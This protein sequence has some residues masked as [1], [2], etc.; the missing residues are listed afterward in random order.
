MRLKRFILPTLL[1]V[2]V[3][4]LAIAPMVHA[5]GGNFGLD[6][7]AGRTIPKTTDLAGLIG[8]MLQTV[9]SFVGVLFLLLMVYAGFVYMTAHGDEKKVTSAKQMITGAIIGVVI[10]ASAYAITSFVLGAVAGDGQTTSATT[11]AAPAEN[12]VPVGG[13]CTDSSQC[14]PAGSTVCDNGKCVS[15]L[16]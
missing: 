9:L 16:E 1:T 3:M 7:A 11:S 10:I 5:Q 15:T 8:K 12:S 4:A 2:G 6:I 14:T 13:N